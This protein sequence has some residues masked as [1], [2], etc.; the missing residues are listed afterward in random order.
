MWKAELRNAPA[1][2][3]LRTNLKKIPEPPEPTP[4]ENCKE[5]LRELI[6]LIKKLGILH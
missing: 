6:V 3:T 5:W 1:V 2:P 4:D